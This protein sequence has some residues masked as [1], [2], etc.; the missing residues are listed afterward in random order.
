MAS[1]ASSTKV[2][3]TI[4]RD[5]AIGACMAA[6][7]QVRPAAALTANVE[8]RGTGFT[9]TSPLAV[10]DLDGDGSMEA[11]L[12]GVDGRLGAFDLRTLAPVWNVQ[13][14]KVPLSSAVVGDFA[15]DG[16]LQVAVMDREGRAHFHRAG[17]GK[18]LAVSPQETGVFATVEA[19]VVPLGG[20]RDGMLV[21]DDAGK[22]YCFG[23]DEG[24]A[25]R[26]WEVSGELDPSQ[27]TGGVRALGR[28]TRPAAVGDIDGDGKPDIAVGTELGVI[29]YFP[30]SEPTLG[31]LPF[32][33]PQG[34]R[35]ATAMVI[36]AF[37]AKGR[38]Q[39]AFATD[40][41][42]IQL[43]EPE[44]T[45][46][47]R[48][49]K[50]VQVA[51]IGGAMPTGAM[52][53]LD[54][55]GDGLMDLSAASA[56]Q[57]PVFDGGA[58]FQSMGD[59]RFASANEALVS[60]PTPVAIKGGGFRV[61]F[62][63][64]RGHV[65][66]V[67]PG[68]KTQSATR[69]E[70][71]LDPAPRGFFAAGDLTGKGQVEMA[72]YTPED[73]RLARATL[74]LAA[75][76]DGVAVQT[77]GVTFAR[78]GQ[79]GPATAARLATARKRFDGRFDD[80]MSQAKTL[81]DSGR[82]TDAG[83]MAAAASGMRPGDASARELAASIGWKLNFARN[84][85][86]AVVVAGAGAFA[87]LRH[88]RGAAKRGRLAKAR[89]AAAGGRASEAL[90]LLKQALA[91][92]P[93]DRD[94]LF[95]AANIY[96]ARSEPPAESLDI[97]RRARAAMPDEPRFALALAKA[98]AAAGDE[99]DDA[100]DCYLLALATMDGE[101]GAVAFR[102]ANV[103]RRRGDLGH[104]EKYYR[105]AL[106]E[107]RP[108]PEVND[109]LAA[110]LVESGQ[111][112]E[113]NAAV[114]EAA[115]GRDPGDPRLAEGLCRAY[116]AARR[117][118]GRARRA[119][120]HTLDMDPGNLAALRLASRCELQAGD[121]PAAA[122]FAERALEADPVDADTVELTANCY[123]AE[124]RRDSDAARVFGQVIAAAQGAGTEPRRDILAALAHSL[125]RQDPSLA[126]E[127]SYRYVKRASVN[128]PEDADLSMGL[129]GA[130]AMH[131]DHAAAA[132]ALERAAAAG[133]N[134]PELWIALAAQYA[135][136]GPAA[137]QTHA[138]RAFRE[139]LRHM[140]DDRGLLANL[141]GLMARL[142]RTDPE[143]LGTLELAVKAGGKPEPTLGK[144]LLRAYLTN[145][146]F[147][148]A[149]RLVRELAQLDRDDAELQKLY[150]QASL[151]TNRLD[152]AIAQYEELARNAPDDREATVNLAMA[153]AQKQRTDADAAA[154]YA[155]ALELQAGGLG[156]VRLMMA[157]HHA[158]AG[159]LD[160]AAE[161]FRRA[162]QLGP[163]I[164]SRVRDEVRT[165]VAAAP[166]RADLRWLLANL[167]VEG[168]EAG[169]AMEHLHAVFEID[170]SQLDQLLHVYDRVLSREP[171]QPAANR[172]KGMLLK[173]KG[174]FEAAR[175]FL[176]K[177]WKLIPGDPETVAE[178]SE[179]YEGIL[180]ES[181]DVGARF[182]QGRLLFS[183]GELDRAAAAFQ[184]TAQD[185][186]Y[187]NESTRMLGQCFARKGMLEFA[188]QEFKKLPVDDEMKA[189]LYDLATQYEEKNDLVG[190]KQVYR[191]LY[192]ADMNYRD[193]KAK[194]DML[195]GSTSDP[196][197][198]ERT[199]L[200][201][202]L[203]EQA[204]HR[205]E[206]IEELGRG[207]M[208]IVYK[209]RDN[210]LDELVALKILP[211]A[212]SQNPDALA[213]F[214]SEARSARRLAHPN[215]VRIHDIGEEM[216]RKYISMEYVEGG[217][218]KR[219][220]RSRGRLDAADIG[221]LIHPVARA[222]DYA[223][224]MQIVHRDIKPANIMISNAGMVKV[225][226]FGIAKMLE[227]AGETMTGAVIGTPLYMSPEQ[228]QG[229]PVDNRS[230]IYSL[231]I[232]MYEFANG[233]PPF[234]E[235]DLAYQHV[236]MPAPPIDDIPA[237]LNA[238]IMKCLEKDKDARWRVAGDV[239]TALEKA[240]LGPPA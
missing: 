156:P 240:G 58:Q 115:A 91:D 41:G 100:H 220:Y 52:V 130:A 46:T 23:L 171:E 196:V 8:A 225:S 198:L 119:A 61:L 206:M 11:L 30:V 209:A 210:E 75:A 1:P 224:S 165:L 64:E 53:A 215:I 155:R 216:G 70:K 107:G 88:R 204:R 109:A 71:P 49:L 184:R 63:T 65:I 123:L 150:A 161:E 239:A 80:L 235:G 13:A 37:T 178:L 2:R 77:Y 124:G 116:L 238:I 127:N 94:A 102:A 108:D 93:D 128:A 114:L 195:A 26:L 12:A 192:A 78:D 40:Q 20:G 87:F 133:R 97:L 15:G 182:A 226:D 185:F 92:D 86:I 201:T 17:D 181:D 120:G 172:Q 89:A 24:K 158:A 180:S 205:Y 159:R 139:A 85:A 221:R 136:L 146:R 174:R 66:A 105:I 113:R 79:A 197:A 170:P 231:G 223:H 188:L 82:P 32:R 106:S 111:F 126:D 99:T 44:G 208:G 36:G 16:A 162:A 125:L 45:G 134:T 145:G 138:E 211:D 38:A 213:R 56:K 110:V 19:T 35:P 176:E 228:I 234:Y 55:D 230:D 167:L 191:M 22:G 153:Y 168:G 5:V 72:Y 83:A 18:E 141:G 227:M 21:F 9:N 169:E 157:R 222:L 137:D 217:D 199:N 43:L 193:V 29:R 60:P 179:L 42:E 207:A 81:R 143:A 173:A 33:L 166:D 10:A 186:R 54:V 117:Q 132:E 144:P 3:R 95:A 187:E 147:D 104:A 7:L 233:R 151:A 160:D 190:A 189:I 175:P 142:G 232:M 14:A 129:A 135:A 57:A 154:V 50:R 39:L 31:C 202:Q 96:A 101:R 27:Q 25:K 76:P 69:T 229:Q 183:T 51:N 59:S 148:D 112:S 62:A 90:T 34:T 214:R 194:F 163:A 236:R 237:E 200:M 203:S 98:A 6:F 121:A 67:D 4:I 122:R 131:G 47:N 140:P 48:K 152:E 28:I 212:L 118:D 73:G 74:D 149:I 218:L 177:A 68:S 103:F 164:E 219:Y 84:G